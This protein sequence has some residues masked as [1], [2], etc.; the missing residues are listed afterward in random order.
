M[1]ASRQSVKKLQKMMEEVLTNGSG[2]GFSNYGIPYNIIGKTGTTQNN[3]DGWFIACSPEI[4]IGLWVGAQDK[5]VHIEST[6]MGSGTGTAMPMVASMF[7]S[8]SRWKNPLLTNF[9]Y[10][11]PY[12]SCL[13]YSD[14][15]A[16]EATDYYKND[17]TYMKSLR[18]RDSLL[19]YPSSKIDSVLVDNLSVQRLLVPEIN[20]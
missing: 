11:Q 3:G 12:F 17:S 1:V 13:D 18:I 6:Y 5:R 16:L 15:K 10:D 2:A 8:L 14:T 9:E 19:A 4:V 20:E 7:K